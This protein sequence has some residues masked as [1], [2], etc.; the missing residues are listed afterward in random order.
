MHRILVRSS[1]V[2]VSPECVWLGAE[3]SEAKKSVGAVLG[4]EGG[5]GTRDVRRR[6]GADLV[7]VL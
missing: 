1:W 6:S 5:L 2:A 4:L 3:M 7:E